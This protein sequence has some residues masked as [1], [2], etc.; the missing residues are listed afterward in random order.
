MFTNADLR[1]KATELF[2]KLRNDKCF[3]ASAGWWAK[4]LGVSQRTIHR[5]SAG[6]S[7]PGPKAA[8]RIIAI[9]QL[10][11]EHKKEIFTEE[12]LERYENENKASL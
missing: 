2:K 4:K 1:T 11:E 7:I 6:Q 9:Y 5:Y 10:V 8:K 12:E 3:V